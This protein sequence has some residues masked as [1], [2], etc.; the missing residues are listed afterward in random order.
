M[1][2]GSCLCG[3]VAFTVTGPL[4]HVIACHCIQCRKTTG[5]YWAAT[6]APRANITMT[7]DDSLTWFDSSDFARR[8]FCAKC[9][10]SLFYERPASGNIA[11]GA[12]CLDAPTGLKE[13]QHIFVADKGDYYDLP[14][15][16]DV[17]AR[18]TDDAPGVPKDQR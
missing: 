14:D 1:H 7:R 10:A 12:G 2:T 3:S 5:H 18:W 9:G 15:C 16:Q 8:G 17:H 13:L 6:S 4:R 11:I